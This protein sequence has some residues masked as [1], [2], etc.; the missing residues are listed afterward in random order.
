MNIRL[1]D[2]FASHFEHI[3]DLVPNRVAVAAR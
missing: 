3:A 2:N 1:E